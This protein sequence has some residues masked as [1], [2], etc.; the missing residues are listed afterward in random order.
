[1]S[2]GVLEKE[3]YM[4]HFVGPSL[5]ITLKGHRFPL[6]SRETQVTVVLQADSHEMYNLINSTEVSYQRVLTRLNALLLVTKSCEKQTC[7]DPWSALH[8]HVAA[9]DTTPRNHISRLDD[10]LHAS[11][12]HYF[13]SF[14]MVQFFLRV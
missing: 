6:P 11:Y 13:A 12:D 10:A 1:M 14:P 5:P 9:N 8:P 3:N 2:H 7:R 4:T